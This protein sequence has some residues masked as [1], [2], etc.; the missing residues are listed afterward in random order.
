MRTLALR[1]SI[2]VTAVVAA[3]TAAVPTASA[4]TL[5]HAEYGAEPVEPTTVSTEH[6]TGTAEYV[7]MGGSYSAGPSIEPIVDAACERSG[8]NYP[9][10]VAR[11]LGLDLRD[12]T[13]SGATTSE[14]LDESQQLADGEQRPPQVTAVTERTRLVTL[15]VGGNDIGHVGNAVLDSC[16]QALMEIAL[17]M[18]YRD[19][20][21][22]AG[23]TTC[24]YLA[25]G[26]ARSDRTLD[27]TVTALSN[28][29]ATVRAVKA[30]APAARIVLVGYVPLVPP[31]SD[32]T[33]CTAAGLSP[34]GVVVARA[35]QEVLDT[36]MRSVAA[37]E[38]VEYLDMNDIAAEHSACAEDPWLTPL[39]LRT[40]ATGTAPLHVTPAG[41]T[42]T[43]DALV[44][45]LRG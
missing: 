24:S 40:I 2:L 42:A 1:R 35:G 8:A 12:V 5:G 16:G 44:A 33:D 23:R 6:P 15:N 32:D 7:A 38:D 25:K 26:G 10:L 45:Y 22:W 31:T 9:T 30:T 4:S 11:E 27:G 13:C 19:P 14:V 18:S 36:V 34:E 43:A 28:L 41:M 39:S 20:V 17:P 3:A 37:A 21:K 29:V